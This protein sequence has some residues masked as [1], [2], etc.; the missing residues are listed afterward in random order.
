MSE[1]MIASYF[2]HFPSIVEFRTYNFVIKLCDFVMFF[3]FVV[4]GN[5]FMLQ[6][7]KNVWS[8]SKYPVLLMFEKFDR[9]G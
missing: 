9:V 1:G 3:S 7:Q 4:R 6:F 8:K 5:I 2:A